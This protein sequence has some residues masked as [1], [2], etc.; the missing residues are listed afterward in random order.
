MVFLKLKNTSVTINDIV[1]M[2][3]A[4]HYKNKFTL[5]QKSKSNPKPKG[6]LKL[7]QTKPELMTFR[8]GDPCFSQSKI[9]MF[10]KKWHSVTVQ[11][12]MPLFFLFYLVPSYSFPLFF[13][14]P[15]LP[16][17]PFIPLF[18]H[19]SWISGFQLFFG[20]VFVKDGCIYMGSILNLQNLV[21]YS[22]PIVWYMPYR[23]IASF[24]QGK[25]LN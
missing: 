5:I 4:L 3:Y 13:P 15:F 9:G 8:L 20:W 23:S 1:R 14:F 25:E 2:V 7:F 12:A 17:S 16:P 10:Y 11:P 22:L 24:K 6:W 21:H 18:P 19:S